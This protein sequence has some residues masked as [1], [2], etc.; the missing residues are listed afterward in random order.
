MN[1]RVADVWWRRGRARNARKAGESAALA[2]IS[3]G[4]IRGSAELYWRRD[5]CDASRRHNRRTLTRNVGVRRQTAED[6]LPATPC[7]ENAR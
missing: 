7:C 5:A 4:K 2:R 3:G 6:E 1:R